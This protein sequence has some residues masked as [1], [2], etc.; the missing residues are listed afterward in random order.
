MTIYYLMVKTHK[1]TGLKYLCQTKRK[2]PHKYLGSGTRWKYH[3]KKHGKTISTEII[4]ECHSNAEIKER[5]LYFSELWDI[6]ES[7]DWANLIPETGEGGSNTPEVIQKAKETK[8]KNK[9]CTTYS[10]IKEKIA[11][12]KI[13]NG[14]TSPKWD[15]A[16]IELAKETKRQRGNG[17]N[18]PSVKKKVRDTKLSKYGTLNPWT[19]KSIEKARQS[20]IKNNNTVANPIVK[21]RMISTR[22]KRGNM[23]CN[24]LDSIKKCKATVSKKFINKYL[25]VAPVVWAMSE[26]GINM[27]SISIALCL[28]WSTVKKII[29]RRALFATMSP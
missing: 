17:S 6:V 7:K 19:E 11:A 10:H 29:E 14:T 4:C 18:S 15:P 23:N 24:T 26:E 3:L 5:G 25:L 16:T 21:A 22:I 27:C 13:K 2:D 1:I 12:T 8:L 9:T 20:R 28:N